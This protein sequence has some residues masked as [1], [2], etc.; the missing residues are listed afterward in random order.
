[1]SEHFASVGLSVAT[2]VTV[3]S[4][5]DN[6]QTE[7][8]LYHIAFDYSYGYGDKCTFLCEYMHAKLISLYREIGQFMISFA[9][10]MCVKSVDRYDQWI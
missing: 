1:M 4:S 3:Y 2:A 8:Y 10:G 9:I 6:C 7:K 5:Y